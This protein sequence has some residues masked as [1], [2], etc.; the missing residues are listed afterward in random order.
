MQNPGEKKKT[1]KLSVV[2]YAVFAVAVIYFAAALG[3]AVDLSAGNDGKVR[4]GLIAD[5]LTKALSAPEVVFKTLG[6]GGYAPKILFFAVI[7]IAIYALYKYSGEKKRLH[8]KGVEHGSAKF[9]DETE[10]NSLKDRVFIGTVKK[11]ADGEIKEIPKYGKIKEPKFKPLLTSDGKRVFDDNGN[12]VGFTIDENIILSKQVYMSLNSRQHLM[13]LNVLI[14]G[15]SGSGKTRFFA[16]P[17]IMQLNTSY[18]I[19]DPKGEILQAVG[20]L[21]MEAGYDLKVLNLI[22]MEHSNNYNPFHYVYDYNGQ[23]SEDNV[24][25][26]IDTFMR[27]TKG[28]GEK[29]DFWSQSAMKTITALIF[30]LFEESEYYA[31]FDVNGKIKPESRDFTH[32]NFFSVAEKMRKL[33]YPPQGKQ[34]GYFFVKEPEETDE[35]FM[36][37]REEAFLCPLDRDFIELESR[38]GDVLAVRL[39]KEIRNSPQETGQSIIATAGA[40]TQMFNLKNVSDL[41]CCDN[42][43][44]ETLGDKKTALFVIISAT[45]ATY[46][47]LAAMMYSQ[48]FDVLANRANFKYGGVLPTPVRCIMDEFANIGQIPDFDKVIAFVRSMGM[49]LNV[50]IQN[51]AQLKARYEKTWEVITGN[52]DSFLFLG[53]KETSTLKDLSEAL[54]KETIDVEVRNRTRTG[55]HKN[56]STA[57]SNSILGRELMTPDELQKMPISDCI[58]TI[59]SKNPFYCQKFPIEKHPNFKFTEDYDKKNA[60]DKNSIKTKTLEEFLGKP[61]KIIKSKEVPEVKDVTLSKLERVFPKP[62]EEVTVKSEPFDYETYAD[63]EMFAGEGEAEIGE[64]YAEPKY[65]AV[66][67]YKEFEMPEAPK[68]GYTSTDGND[69]EN[70]TE[71]SD[72]NEPHYSESHNEF[73]ILENITEP[74]F[75]PSNEEENHARAVQFGLITDDYVEKH[76]VL[77]I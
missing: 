68:D 11:K 5:G 40:R 18:V 70:E 2:I 64:E 66:S 46:Y 54:G 13:N 32:L 42:I 26:M 61:G 27:N 30:L 23:L 29:D 62:G 25:K 15:G 58:L 39:Y 77:S 44:L 50:I 65:G 52:C 33:Q 20:K 14:I 22:E 43:Q 72:Y 45:S 37:R 55:G 36:K 34:D 71:E 73:E 56:D 12:F 10:M 1:D 17:N 60:F 49:S 3:T 75:V 69:D 53:G 7:A 16:K 38:K 21:L 59:R 74:S 41:T 24:T 48:M 51:L 67:E 28:E 47:F 76:Y 57:E 63:A 8:R 19:T 31:E 6:K 4:G 35:E 9:G